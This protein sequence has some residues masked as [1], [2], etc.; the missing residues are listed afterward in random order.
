VPA[1]GNLTALFVAAE[2]G[3]DEVVGLLV[4]RGLNSTW[5]VDVDLDLRTGDSGPL[6]RLQWRDGMTALEVAAQNAHIESF[7]LLAA[8]GAVVDG[9][10]GLALR[11]AA[12]NGHGLLVRRLV[13]HG[14]DL[15]RRRVEDGVTPLFI[16]A[17]NGFFDVAREFVAAG[18]D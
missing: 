14:A 18:A 9:G 16:A 8:A 3:H 4:A 7:L 6:G 13:E 11:L 5:A 12:E 2:H 1:T 10:D 17:H 15:D